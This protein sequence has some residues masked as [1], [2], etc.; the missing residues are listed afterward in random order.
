MI[1]KIFC[2]RDD[3]FFF[4]KE[5]R[6]WQNDDFIVWIMTDHFVAKL[7]VYWPNITIISSAMKE[8]YNVF[9]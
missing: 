8:N 7:M 1:A 6:L 5:N 2:V 9:I 4:F 3:I